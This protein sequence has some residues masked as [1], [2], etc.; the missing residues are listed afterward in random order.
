MCGDARREAMFKMVQ[1]GWMDGELIP[2]T[3]V[4]IVDKSR[5]AG[6]PVVLC[7]DTYHHGMSTQPVFDYTTQNSITV[8]DASPETGE[9][10]ASTKNWAKA[11]SAILAQIRRG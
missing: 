1:D 2:P 3:G 4:V 11:F 8:V 6:I 7:T 10:N 5:K 9:G